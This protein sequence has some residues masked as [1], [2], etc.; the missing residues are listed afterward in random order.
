MGISWNE[1]DHD[2]GY[3]FID[4]KNQKKIDKLD[5]LEKEDSETIFNIIFSENR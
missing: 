1:S 4:Q 2:D 5:T 3:V